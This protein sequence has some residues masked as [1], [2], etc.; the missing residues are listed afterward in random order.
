MKHQIESFDVEAPTH[1]D[2]LVGLVRKTATETNIGW[3]QSIT[4]RMPIVLG[5]TIDAL[6]QYSSQSRNKL[7]VK[8]LETALDQVWEQL[9]ESERVDIERIRSE[10][11]G[12]KVA[13]LEKGDKPE[14]G[15]V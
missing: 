1:L 10:I 4:I 15:E 14:S 7:I 8:A 3:L 13:S 5:C 11:L 12:E 2:Q 9:P 6:A